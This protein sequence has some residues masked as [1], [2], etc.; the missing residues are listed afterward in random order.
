MDWGWGRLNTGLCLALMIRARVALR[1]KG[2]GC[3]EGYRL[4][5]H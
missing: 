3:T 2:W 1:V 4:G 5:L